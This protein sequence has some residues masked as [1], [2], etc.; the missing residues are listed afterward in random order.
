MEAKTVKAT[1]YKDLLQHFQQ[2]DKTV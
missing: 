2:A 1:S